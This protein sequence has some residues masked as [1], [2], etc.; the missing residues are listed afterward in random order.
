MQIVLL[1]QGQINVMQKDNTKTGGRYTK[2]E[3]EER[4]NKVFEYYFQKGLSALE[5]ADILVVNRNTVNA[6]VSYLC[7]ELLKGDKQ[8]YYRNGLEKQFTKLEFQKSRLQK[9]LDKELEFKERYQIEKYILQIDLS[10]A[11]MIVK[12]DTSKKFQEL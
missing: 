9:E 5:I 10:I 1:Q 3:Q 4:R 6:D 8:T 11:N 7:S 12:I 2:P